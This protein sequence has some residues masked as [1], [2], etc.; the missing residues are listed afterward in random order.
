MECTWKAVCDV[1]E[2]CMVR[3]YPG[4]N[5]TTHCIQV[6]YSKTLSNP[7]PVKLLVRLIFKV[8]QAWILHRLFAIPLHESYFL[9]F[10]WS[11]IFPT[12]CQTFDVFLF[13]NIKQIPEINGFQKIENTAHTCKTLE[14]AKIH[15]EKVHV[16]PSWKI[17]IK[18]HL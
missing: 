8:L 3:W 12:T 15:I 9:V 1:T 10:H 14:C 17:P 18:K 5:F 2:T 11:Y 13:L 6:I 4:F 7:A 16:Y